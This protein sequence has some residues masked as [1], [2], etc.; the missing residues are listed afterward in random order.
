VEDKGIL[1]MGSREQLLE[2]NGEYA[3]LE[4]AQAMAEARGG[5]ER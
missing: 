3:R 5:K 2:M 4:R 1:E